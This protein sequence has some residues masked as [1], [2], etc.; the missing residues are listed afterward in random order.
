MPSTLQ[1]LLD[2]SVWPYLAGALAISIALVCYAV[3]E[4]RSTPQASAASARSDCSGW[5][6]P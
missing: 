6:L 2:P 4:L 1:L 5:E 3:R